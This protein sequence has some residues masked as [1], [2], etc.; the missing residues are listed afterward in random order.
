MPRLSAAI[1]T[2]QPLA[3]EDFVKAEIDWTK[4]GR[5]EQ[6]NGVTITVVTNNL[7][8]EAERV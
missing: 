6:Q 1:E 5:Q 2:N 4:F 7:L 8:E 3:M